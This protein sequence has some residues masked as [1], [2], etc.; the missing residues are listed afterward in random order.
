V[1]KPPPTPKRLRATLHPDRLPAK[2]GAPVTPPERRKD[3]RTDTTY[4]LRNLLRVRVER[5]AYAAAVLGTSDGVLLAGSR[6]DLLAEGLVAE[7]S[8]E[9]FDS[10]APYGRFSRESSTSSQR[11]SGVR[12]Q[13]D[14]KTL[15]LA[16][17]DETGANVEFDDDEVLDEITECVGRILA[18]RRA[19]AALAA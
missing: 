19:S 17:L 1:V 12:I 10:R 6:E 7:A 3:P 4:S 11:L 2:E 15:L 13:V 5:H 16:L 18:E 14:G 9:L 8:Y